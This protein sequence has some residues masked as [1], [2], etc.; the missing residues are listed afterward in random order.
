MLPW[1]RLTPFFYTRMDFGA[2]IKAEEYVFQLIGQV[3]MAYSSMSI[4][5]MSEI[6]CQ[7][8]LVFGKFDDHYSDSIIHHLSHTVVLSKLLFFVM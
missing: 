2:K 4:C 1:S 8:C 6:K 7:Y 5:V 3:C